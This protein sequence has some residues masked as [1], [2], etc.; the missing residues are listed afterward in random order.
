[1]FDESQILVWCVT[2]VKSTDSLVA[3]IYFGTTE[4]EGQFFPF[5]IAVNAEINQLQAEI[6]Q[7]K[8]E[9]NRLNE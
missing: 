2:K 9:I 4:R 7:L 3:V 1:M 5:N 8:V 6:N